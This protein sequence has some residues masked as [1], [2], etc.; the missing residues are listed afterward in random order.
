MLN[1]I[2]GNNW[3]GRMGNELLSYTNERSTD[4]HILGFQEVNRNARTAFP[5]AT[6]VTNLRD[7]Q[8]GLPA[9][10]MINQYEMLESVLSATHKGSFAAEN[11]DTYKCV[12]GAEYPNTEYGNALFVSHDLME[13]ERGEIFIL[14]DYNV[15][16]RNGST[17]RVMPY[18]VFQ[19]KRNMYLFAFEHGVWYQDTVTKSTKD[20]GPIRYAQSANIL[21]AIE[22]LVNKF[23]ITRVIFGGDLNLDINTDAIMMLER[24][25][26]NGKMPFR[27]LI[28][29]MNILN[30]RV[31]GKYRDYHTL[32]ASRY[33]DYMFV[34]EE[35]QVHDLKLI[36]EKVSDHFHLQLQ[37]S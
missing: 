29:E 32:G 6:Y 37:F 28:R 23:A 27:N 3:G 36:G 33:A 20:D 35:I 25:I 15:S 2:V 13:I 9:Q 4:T 22:R 21:S 11:N 12:T 8:K 14:G 7:F 1:A 19:W 24:G 5:G 17:S 10:I 18:V 34:S 30:T 26:H 31:E 16:L